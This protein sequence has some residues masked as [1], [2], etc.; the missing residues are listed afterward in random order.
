MLM[1]II[2]LAACSFFLWADL[3]PAQSVTQPPKDAPRVVLNDLRRENDPK[4]SKDE[5]AILSTV[6]RYL[7]HQNK[8]PLDAYYKFIKSSKGYAVFV[9]F[10]GGYDGNR[11]LFMPGGFCEVELDKNGKV[12]RVDPG[13]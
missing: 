11:P 4:F 5:Q 2:A 3:S 7:E 6:R 1:K 9:Q 8:T 12:L 10:V 13:A